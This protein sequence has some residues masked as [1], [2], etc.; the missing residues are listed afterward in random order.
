MKFL[1]INLSK[2][3]INKTALRITLYN[4]VFINYVCFNLFDN[5]L[6]FLIFTL[7]KKNNLKKLINFLFFYELLM[8]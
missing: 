5:F 3:L 8:Q 2:Q 4:S 6:Y 7:R 1:L